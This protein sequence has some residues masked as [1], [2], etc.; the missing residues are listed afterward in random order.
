M[1]SGDHGYASLQPISCYKYTALLKKKIKRISGLDEKEKR[2]SW[3]GKEI[4][5]WEP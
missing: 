5:K 4:N 1:E 2:E 3:K